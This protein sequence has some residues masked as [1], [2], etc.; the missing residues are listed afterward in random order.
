M[1][2]QPPLPQDK[3]AAILDEESRKPKEADHDDPA[4]VM[5]GTVKGYE[6]IDYRKFEALKLAG[7]VYEGTMAPSTTVTQAAQAYFDWLT[8]D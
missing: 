2:K 1:P 6:P 7:Q 8:S 4:T 3:E 5:Q